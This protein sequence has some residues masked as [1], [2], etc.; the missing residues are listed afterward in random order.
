[1]RAAADPEVS[2][3]TARQLEVD[4]ARRTAD[5]DRRRPSE[6]AR[7]GSGGSRLAGWGGL[8]LGAAC[9]S[10]VP[11]PDLRTPRAVD[12]ARLHFEYPGN[13][14]AWREPGRIEGLFLTDHEV[15]GLG[16]AVVAI[17]AY[18]AQVRFDPHD[19]ADMRLDSLPSAIGSEAVR[20]S[21]RAPVS[22]EV[23]GH[24][25]DGVRLWLAPATDGGPAFTMEVFTVASGGH[26]LAVTT[27]VAE[28]H[29][30]VEG[31][32]VDLVIDSLRLE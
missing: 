5:G 15:V 26:S 20:V 19:I 29:A 21:R 14:T 13:W 17:T 16:S 31:P 22:R 8:V 23:A 1:M 32:G 9:G 18:D 2:R 11:G 7:G 24:P 27:R 3:E 4:M 28:A 25:V 30:D 10:G 12:T 6:G